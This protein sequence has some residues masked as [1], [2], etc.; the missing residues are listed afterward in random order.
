MWWLKEVFS[1]LNNMN[2]ANSFRAL[3]K[4]SLILAM[5]S[6][7]ACSS[8]DSDISN[9]GVDEPTRVETTG[10]VEPSEEFYIVGHHLRRPRN[11][12]PKTWQQARSEAGQLRGYVSR[13]AT[14]AYLA[15]DLQVDINVATNVGNDLYR[16]LQKTGKDRSVQAIAPWHPTSCYNGADSALDIFLTFGEA[17]VITKNASIIQDVRSYCDLK[18][19]NSDHMPSSIDIKLAGSSHS[20]TLVTFNLELGK[21]ADVVAVMNVVRSYI[22]NGAEVLVLTEVPESL[23]PILGKEF[24]GYQVFQAPRTNTDSRGNDLVTVLTKSSDIEVTGVDYPDLGGPRKSVALKVRVI[25]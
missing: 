12:R 21:S 5:G 18:S 13:L 17:G 1:V 22:D 2:V 16:I 3:V 23:K 9:E 20:F 15:G 7:I 14:T 24:G 8:S 10:S 11:D 6:L 25:R 4:F 19:L